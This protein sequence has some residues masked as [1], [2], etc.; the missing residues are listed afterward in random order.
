MKEISC[1]IKICTQESEGRCDELVREA[2][3]ATRR[4]QA[5]LATLATKQAEVERLL[6][7]LTTGAQLLHK[8][9][10]DVVTGLLI[11]SHCCE[12]GSSVFKRMRI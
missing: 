9:P 5:A 10:Q 7:E 3:A 11:H 6:E 1:R 12:S 4:E 2:Q 8:V